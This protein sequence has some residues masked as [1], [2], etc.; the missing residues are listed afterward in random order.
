MKIAELCPYSL[1]VPGGV[2][3]QVLL[4][5]RTMRQLG[6]EVDVIAPSESTPEIEFFR[7]LG[8]SVRV[9]ANGSRAP[10]GLSPGALTRTARFVRGGGYQII[11]IHEPFA[12]GP[13]LV[14]LLAGKS[15][16]VGTFH[17]QGLSTPY[18][19]LGRVISRFGER[20]SVRFAVSHD[21]MITAKTVFGGDYRVIGNGVDLHEFD[22][23]NAWP[24]Q[25]PTVFFIGRH[26]HRK[27]LEV[28]I[29]AFMGIA[30][31]DLT[32]WVA[33]SGPETARL[34]AVAARDSR[35]VWLGRI[36][37]SEVIS[38]MK[39]A[40]VVCAPSLYGESFGVVLLEGMAAG[41]VVVA[42]DIVGY[43]GLA[44]NGVEAI[45]VPPNDASLLRGA[46]MRALASDDV[47]RS[48]RENARKRAF[49]FSIE[50]IAKIYLASFTTL[51]SEKSP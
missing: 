29:R 3:R 30:E 47:S 46:L 34:K 1:S 26:E 25:S 11:H 21:A 35:I 5:A 41:S 2:Q 40:D 24:K 28:L 8:S 13:S 17:R 48:I 42:T 38:R 39:A 6:H 23:A 49:E 20:L 32:C 50:N 19:G 27:G 16:L 44:R 18:K 12:P 31:P 7:N 10:V 15:P 33:G 51:I 37:D 43:S 4:L 9:P 14:G 36:S 22:V 45:L